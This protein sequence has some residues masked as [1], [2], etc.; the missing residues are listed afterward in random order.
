VGRA[1]QAVLAFYSWKS[2]AVY[3]RSSMET[4]PVAYDTF[5]TVF[6][7]EEP[8]FRSTIRVIRDFTCRRGLR[9]KLAMVSII[10]AMIYVLAWPTLAS[11]MTGY[12]SAS[13]AFVIDTAQN[14][15][16]FSSFVPVA[17]IIHDGWRIQRTG[18]FIVTTS[19]GESSPG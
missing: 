4:A 6:L 10:T 8:S 2:F 18:D 13:G 12:T 14:L 19:M 11:A 15:I 9:S 1:G 3:V 16:S 7:E 5:F 17:Y